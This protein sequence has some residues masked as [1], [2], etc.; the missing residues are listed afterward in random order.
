MPPIPSSPVPRTE[1]HAPS[2]RARLTPVLAYGAAAFAAACAVAAVL[3]G[4]GHRWG[5]WG[6]RAGLTSVVVAAGA[7]ALPLVVGAVAVFLA[8]S[9]TRFAPLIAALSAVVIAAATVAPVAN[10]VRQA[11]RL[12]P[13]H[14]ISTDTDDPPRFVAVLPLRRDAANP[15]DYGG[16]EVA[17]QQKRAYPDIVP[18][19]LKAPPPAVFETAVNAARSLG[20]SVAAAVPAEGRIEATDT[21]FWFGFKDDVVIRI[22]PADGGS[23]IDVRSVSRVGRGDVGANARRIRHFLKILAAAVGQEPVG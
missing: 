8:R 14:D 11:R 10:Q 17:R 1:T 2:V 18:L 15:A 5:W 6:Y 22:R 23:R 3:S 4:L 13:I 19:M 7:A 20:W 16:P 21:T 12:P 9:Q